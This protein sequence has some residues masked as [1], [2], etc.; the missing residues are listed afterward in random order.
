M[1]NIDH[2]LHGVQD[3][4]PEPIFARIADLESQI[5]GLRVLLRTA[6]Q[7]RRTRERFKQLETPSA[8]SANEVSHVD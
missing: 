2:L 3:L 4:E 1:T 8:P 5:A 7:R 6:L